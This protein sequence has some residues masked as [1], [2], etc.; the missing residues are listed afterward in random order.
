MTEWLPEDPDGGVLIAARATYKNLL[1]L[2]YD[3]YGS[4]SLQL[5]VLKKPS[6]SPSVVASDSSFTSLPHPLHGSI[7]MTCDPGCPDIFYSH[8]S[9]ADPGTLYHASIRVDPDHPDS[10][11]VSVVPIRLRPV[12]LPPLTSSPTSSSQALKARKKAVVAVDM[13]IYDTKQVLVPLVSE[14]SGVSRTVPVYISGH[15]SELYYRQEYSVGSDIM[16]EESKQIDEAVEPVVPEKFCILFVCSD[17]G[18]VSLQPSY[19]Q[20]AFTWMHTYRGLFCAVNITPG[21]EHKAHNSDLLGHVNTGHTS[22]LS[23]EDFRGVIQYLVDNKYASYKTLGLL[24]GSGGSS[25]IAAFINAYPDLC[26]AAVI[27]SGDI[28]SVIQAGPLGTAATEIPPSSAI[29]SKEPIG[30]SHDRY[31]APAPPHTAHIGHV[32]PLSHLGLLEEVALPPLTPI[33]PSPQPS[34][35][36]SVSSENEHTSATPSIAGSTP[37]R[38]AF[39]PTTIPQ[40]R[41]YSSL[42]R[43]PSP[44]DSSPSKHS[45]ADAGETEARLDYRHDDISPLVTR[46]HPEMLL[47]DEG[48]DAGSSSWRLAPTSTHAKTNT[49]LTPPRNTSHPQPSINRLYETPAAAPLASFAPKRY[50][51]VLLLLQREADESIEAFQTRQQCALDLIAYINRTAAPSDKVS[52]TCLLYHKFSPYTCIINSFALLYVESMLAKGASGHW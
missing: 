43:S 36:G 22:P 20:S 26:G 10:V 46:D 37:P 27:D 1:V 15:R 35:S 17:P 30:T 8:S 40:F 52:S 23:V 28:S 29:A 48:S 31:Q 11:V 6:L 39:Y 5:H 14:L 16:V 50:P 41:P 19:S 9:F 13:T 3:R 38:D 49:K 44:G 45:Q 24:A 7:A 32:P 47:G 34:S 2:Q 4:H 21:V 18:I 42:I 51:A 25:L 12:L 33:R